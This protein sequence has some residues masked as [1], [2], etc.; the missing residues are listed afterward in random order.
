MQETINKGGT[1]HQEL[2]ESDKLKVAIRKWKTDLKNL[3]Q[4]V[5]SWSGGLKKLN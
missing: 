1:T 5:I 3:S 4:K 2:F